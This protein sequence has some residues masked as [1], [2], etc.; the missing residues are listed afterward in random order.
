MSKPETL[1]LKLYRR[2]KC[3]CYICGRHMKK[4]YGYKNS[5]TIDHVIPKSK[6]RDMPFGIVPN[7]KRLA[8]FDCNQK[9]GDKNIWEVK[10]FFARKETRND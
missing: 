1:F 9:K 2:Q 8:C 3:K 5:A 4:E 7:N 6:L 10:N